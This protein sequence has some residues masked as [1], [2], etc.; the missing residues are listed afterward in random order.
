MHAGAALRA[1][2][3]LAHALSQ[4]LGGWT[5]G[6]HGGF[7]A[8]CL[9]VVLRFNAEVAAGPIAQL[10]EAMGVPDAAVRAE[11]LARLGGFTRLRELGVAEADL[12]AIAELPARGSVPGST[13]A[14][15][16]RPRPSSCCARSGERAAEPIRTANRLYAYCYR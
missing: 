1:G 6:S 14:R 7:N 10:A 3:G 12:P 16:Q 4:A 11:E 13:R 9:P 15:R 8:L 5:G 2:F